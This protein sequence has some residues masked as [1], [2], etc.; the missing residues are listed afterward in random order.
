MKRWEKMFNAH[1]KEK[2]KKAGLAILISHK[3]DFE[4]K[5]ITRNNKDLTI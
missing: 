3:I 1:G 5:T 2:K 4:T